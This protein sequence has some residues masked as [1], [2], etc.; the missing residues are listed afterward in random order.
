M[1]WKLLIFFYLFLI[2]AEIA[3][4]SG[5]SKAANFPDLFGVQYP[6]YCVC[7]IIICISSIVACRFSAYF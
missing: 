6:E 2:E 5:E 3:F 1:D 7:Y 4:S